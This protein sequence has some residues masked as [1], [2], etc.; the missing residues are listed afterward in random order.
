MHDTTSHPSPLEQLSPEQ[1]ERLAELLD[2][3]LSSREE[4]VAPDVEAMLAAHPD[5]AEAFRVSLRGLEFLDRAAGQISAPRPPAGGPRKQLARQ[6]GDFLLIREVGRGG[7][8]I[9]YLARQISLDR[10]VALKV[11]PFAAV[12]DQK[13]ITRFE[14]EAR[15]AAQLHHPNIVPVF[16]P[17]KSPMSTEAPTVSSVNIMI[18]FLRFPDLS[19]STP[20]KGENK[21]RNR[22]LAALA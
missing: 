9:V 6:L 8:G 16:M 15:A 11:L 20:N 17:P 3:Y 5:L 13:Q 7:M 22:A 18:Y 14:N 2:G 4:V 21:I 10:R 1:Q 12:L 19:I